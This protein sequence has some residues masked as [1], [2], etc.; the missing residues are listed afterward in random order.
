MNRENNNYYCH[1]RY[2]V[3]EH[4]PSTAHAV[5]SVGCGSGVTEAKLVD[6]GVKVVGLE[7]DHRAAEKARSQGLSVIEV[8]AAQPCPAL[9]G[10]TFDCLIYAD[11]LE[12]LLD[13]V[14][15][16]KNH[17]RYLEPGGI[18]IISV[19]NFR[20]YSVFWQQF[21]LGRVGYTNAGIFDR[22]HIRITTRKT[23][24]S[25]MNEVGLLAEGCSYI[26]NRRR[27]RYLSMTMLGLF[28][29]I[30]AQQVIIKAIRAD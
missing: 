16:L 17:C 19:P 10:H 18:V 14:A 20:H 21:M 5:L 13:P 23:V 9:A 15:V 1:C 22:T 6:R 8:D 7:L 25:W 27:D 2:E 12:H 4:V 29:E 26:F 30:L 28:K 24:I 3:L 11:I